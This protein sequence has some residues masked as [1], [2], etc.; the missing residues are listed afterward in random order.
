MRKIVVILLI[1]SQQIHGQESGCVSGD[2]TNGFG[3]FIWGSDT[4]WAGHKYIGMWKDGARDGS[5]TYYYADGSQ[6]SGEYENNLR[7]GFGTFTWK[8]G[9]KY[10]GL[11][12][13]D[14]QHGHGTVYSTDGTFINGIWENGEF[15]REENGRKTGCTE[16]NCED[17]FGVYVW[18]TG[19]KYEGYWKNKLRNGMGTNFYPSGNKYVGEWLND[20]QHGTGTMTYANGEKYS[21]E[22]KNHE[23]EG[24]GTFI[25]K[26]GTKYVG[27]FKNHMYH[28]FG[29][30]YSPN[31]ITQ[32]GFWENNVFIGKKK[33]NKNDRKT[34]C[35]TGNCENGFG[36]YIW[37]NGERYEGYWENSLRNGQGENYFA[38]GDKFSG[39]FKDDLIHGYGTYTF[40]EG[41][42]YT[43]LFNENIKEGYGTYLFKKTGEKYEGYWKND[44]YNG[45]GTF[46]KADGTIQSGIWYNGEYVRKG[47]EAY[48]CISGNCANGYGTYVFQ[49]GS[50]Y[51]GNFKYDTYSGKG[52]FFFNNGDKYVGNF[53]DGMFDGRG[54]YIFSL[55]GR[56]YVGA[57]SNNSFNGK[58]TLYYATGE[59]KT[60]IWKNNEYVGRDDIVDAKPVVSWLY[61][62]YFETKSSTPTFRI[63]LC[64][65][66]ETELK[67][68][69]ILNNNKLIMTSDIRGFKPISAKCDFQ[70]DRIVTLK[71]GTNK[72]EIEVENNAGVSKSGVRTIVYGNKVNTQRFALVIGINEYVSAPLRN[73]VNDATSMANSLEGFGFDVNLLTDISR[74]EMKSEI[75]AF[76]NSLAKSG[77]VGLFYFAGHGIQINGENYLVPVDAHI[78][79]SQDVELEAVN[80]KRILGEMDYAQNNMNI[81]ILDACRNNPFVT[82]FRSGGVTGL[83]STLAPQGTFIAYS[84]APGSIAADGEG[85]NSLYTEELLKAMKIPNMKIEDVFKTVRKNVYQKSQKMQVPWENSSIFEDFFFL[86]D[87]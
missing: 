74:N 79:K 55:D 10:V 59:T 19:E 67:S 77:G 33:P 18:D 62:E 78:E 22:Y 21:G 2:C 85:Q 84:T 68:V 69:K 23:I 3:T 39:E 86:E 1:L 27:E 14:K 42:T 47:D 28:G 52:T 9:E 31:G 83:A 29:T 71:N 30:L 53:R 45:E 80:L 48:G 82:N 66:S 17:G 73:P 4:E 16:G 15:I 72:I 87:K 50:K 8:S 6:Y 58:G 24:Q 63:K 65:E 81:I 76:G 43:G 25:T 35:I 26:D 34:E 5:G 57:F 38:N 32:T 41:D 44:T 64:I 70:I 51:I 61:P 46:F 40:K 56:K 49:N 54:T 11:W 60:G 7:H 36:V 13:N 75:R 12:K 20:K 37:A